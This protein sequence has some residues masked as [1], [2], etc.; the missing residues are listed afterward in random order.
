MPIISLSISDDL[1]NDI[2]TFAKKQG[3][4]GKSELARAALSGYIDLHYSN[5]IEPSNEY[6]LS[7]SVICS[8]GQKHK[9]HEIMHNVSVRSQFH[10][11]LGRTRC[12]EVFGI[13][14]KGKELLI[15]LQ[16]LENLPKIEKI[17]VCIDK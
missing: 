6:T 7:L 9:V 8:E 5:L 3:D 16:E 11:C 14:A 4:M 17:Q 13:T 2:E 15:A 12:I 1:L 10:L